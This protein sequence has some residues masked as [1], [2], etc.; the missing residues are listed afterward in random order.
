EV[1]FGNLDELCC[2]TYA[3]CK[4][5]LNVILQYVNTST[6]VNPTDI[7][8]RLFQKW[9]NRDSRCKKLQLTD[10]LVSPVQHIMRVP[11]I[12]KDIEIRT[13]GL[14]EKES[15]TAII[16]SEENSLRELDDK[17][18]WLKNFERLLEIQRNIVWPSVFDL[19][20]KVFIPEF[21]KAPLSK[22][23]CERLI[24]SP[25]RQI[26]I[27]GPLHILDSGKPIEMYVI[28][29]DDMLIITR[30][31]KGLHKKQSSLTEKWASTCSRG[32]SFTS[33]HEGL[34]KYVVY[35]QPLSLDRFYI[36]DVLP[37]SEGTATNLKN[38]FVLVCLNRFQ[39]VV[40]LH[41][42]Q[43]STESS[44]VTWLSKLR[45]TADKWKRTLQNTVF[46]NQQR[47]SS[48][49]VSTAASFRDNSSTTHTISTR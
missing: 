39:Q 16:E 5:F 40:T 23:P 7:L 38:V 28:L 46:R 29:F 30:R 8:V 47:L 36:H 42:F 24:V 31:K 17:M 43:S 4:E 25:R 15:I 12:L 41:T 6:E 34:F 48:G 26:I 18:K 11:L 22:Q 1:L 13:D 2:V 20:P 37:G 32:S 44:K 45:D 35:K 49:S 19:D 27:E 3:F 21:L 33:S 9:C 10:L 14:F